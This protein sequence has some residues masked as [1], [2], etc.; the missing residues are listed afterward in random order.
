MTARRLDRVQHLNMSSPDPRD[1]YLLDARYL[2][3]PPVE[4]AALNEF[5]LILQDQLDPLYY[6]SVAFPYPIDPPLLPSLTST[7]LR[8]FFNQRQLHL[9]AT[10]I[11]LEIEPSDYVIPPAI[12]CPDLTVGAFQ[13]APPPNFTGSVSDSIDPNPVVIHLRDEVAGVNPIVITRFYQA[14]DASGNT[15]SWHPNHNHP[16]ST[17]RF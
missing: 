9:D 7:L 15:S 8:V 2:T 16:L 10:L 1:L 3:G 17:G 13:E 12:I 14:T 4:G 6:A 11:Q 5:I